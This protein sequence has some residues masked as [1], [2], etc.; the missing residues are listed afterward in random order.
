MPPGTIS[1]DECREILTSSGERLVHRTFMFF[2]IIALAS[3]ASPDSGAAQMRRSSPGGEPPPPSAG[4]SA[5]PRIPASTQ[6]PFVG[7]WTGQQVVSGRTVPI[8][9]DIDS[10]SGTYT[11]F[12][13]WPNDARAP[14]LNSHVVDGQLHWEQ[15]NS[16]G[17]V[18]V[19]QAKRTAA[20]SLVG[21]VTLRGAPGRESAPPSGT[22][23]LVR[24]PSQ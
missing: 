23:V 12:T 3:V 1:R 15:Q 14:H 18:W 20:D 2:A 6:F 7:S 10:S 8:G 4:G 24:M 19:Y 21:T 17:G 13:I 9:V 5:R 11:G 22:F 16:G